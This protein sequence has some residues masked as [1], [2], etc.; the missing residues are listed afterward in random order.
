[1]AQPLSPSTAP[2]QY[3][4][5]R[6]RR[7]LYYATR[8]L[9][10]ILSGPSRAGALP[11]RCFPFHTRVVSAEKATTVRPQA[12]G[13]R[14]AEGIDPPEAMPP[15]FKLA[16]RVFWDASFDDQFV[17][18]PLMMK[19]RLGQSRLRIHAKINRV[20]DRQNR[21]ADDGRSARGA[22]RQDRP[23]VLQNDGRAHA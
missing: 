9:S 10:W 5:R 11:A 20:D 18:F 21:L 7:R 14:G 1:A 22:N 2:S 19:T 23:A 6:F 4:S 15:L 12:D 16:Q 3:S 13:L 17:R 8:F